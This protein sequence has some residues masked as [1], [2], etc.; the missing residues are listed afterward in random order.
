M[1]MDGWASWPRKA[2]HR[3]WGRRVVVINDKG[4]E[5]VEMDEGH[6]R[7]RGERG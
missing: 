3:G 1:V 5:F 2:R 6:E 7:K 4:F